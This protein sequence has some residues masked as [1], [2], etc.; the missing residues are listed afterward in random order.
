M[1]QFC[2]IHTTV[3]VL[4]H[5]YAWNSTV[6]C[7]MVVRMQPRHFRNMR[8]VGQFGMEIR[9]LRESAELSQAQLAKQAGI[10][11]RWAW[12]ARTRPYRRGT[13]QHHAPHESSRSC[14]Q[15]REDP[16]IIGLPDL[17]VLM[18]GVAAARLRRDPDGAL[19]L[20]YNEKYL[21]SRSSVPLSLSLP[22]SERP[23]KDA[24]TTC[25]IRS[26]LPDNHN[27]LSRWYS[28]EDVLERTLFG[29]LSTR[30]GLDCAGA[31]Q[32]CP[33]GNEERISERASGIKAL[34]PSEFKREL[35]TTVG[36][37]NA[38]FPE[39]VEPYFSLG[40]FQSKVALHRVGN[41]WGRPYGNVPTTHILKPRAEGSKFVAIAEH[42]CLSA[43]S[44]LG[45]NAASSSIERH[46]DNTV[47][48][49]ERYDRSHDKE[50]WTRIHQE[51]MCQALGMDG[52]R[53]YEHS[54]GPGIS[55]IGDLIALHS[56]QP[57]R[58]LRSFAEAL[59]YSWLVVNRDAHSQ[60]LQ[61]GVPA[62]RCATRPA[63]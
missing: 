16:V 36:D 56:T 54:G 8:T 1:E 48:V 5:I 42:L 13:R 38:W 51:D 35:D 14:T 52:A 23:H 57:A 3:T 22:F 4:F 24:A 49:V 62:G 11:R 28:R 44:R 61:L 59:I 50:R 41:G 37:P 7:A 40:G 20:V 39:D 34:T 25:W 15:I 26:L 55:H 12:T 53:K 58:D 21:D 17:S 60:E 63:V 45:L 46:G 2:S 6:T 33:V 19:S 32:F 47:L 31:V 29:L 30:I 18:N 43:A 9:R 27:V 10:S